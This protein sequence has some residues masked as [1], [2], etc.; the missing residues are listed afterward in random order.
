M[1]ELNTGFFCFSVGF[2]WK[3]RFGLAGQGH[4]LPTIHTRD[5]KLKAFDW[6]ENLG[7][8]QGRGQMTNI[9]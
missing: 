8:F 4:C 9:D 3:D 5:D 2:Y 6:W 1:S 7:T